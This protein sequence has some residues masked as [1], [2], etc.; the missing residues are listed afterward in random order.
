MRF[1][2]ESGRSARVG[3]ERPWLRVMATGT[4]ARRSRMS[5]GAGDCSGLVRHA[6]SGPQLIANERGVGFDSPVQLGRPS[7]RFPKP[8]FLM[9]SAPIG[10]IEFVGELAECPMGHAH[11]SAK[12]GTPTSNTAYHRTPSCHPALSWWNTS[13]LGHC[14]PA[15]F[16]G[17][18]SHLSPNSAGSASLLPAVRSLPAN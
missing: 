6:A 12:R 11:I 4:A 8:R 15:S 3:T 18:A 10:V 17:M 16:E 5:E 2:D 1:L 14:Q 7:H 13:R 9:A